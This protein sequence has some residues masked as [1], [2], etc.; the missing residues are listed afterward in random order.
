MADM[1]DKL[2]EV[3]TD[4]EVLKKINSIVGESMIPKTE[5]AKAKEQ[6]KSKDE[7]LVKIRESQMTN[8]ELLKHK[9]EEVEQAKAE[10]QIK[11]NRVEA[12]ALFVAAG[13]KEEDY[14]DLLET[15]VSSDRERTLGLVKKFIA[16][17]DKEKSLTESK[18][19]ESLLNQTERP[20]KSD[21]TVTQKPLKFTL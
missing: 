17:V 2:K 13:I 4:E 3:V 8:E 5:Y 15:T 6:V 1:Y 11:N 20:E 19:K 10:L 9:L 14:N 21:T 16:V 7:E 12:K 18:T